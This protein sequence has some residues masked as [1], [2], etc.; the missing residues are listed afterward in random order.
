MPGKCKVAFV[1][2]VILTDGKAATFCWFID[3][4]LCAIYVDEVIYLI[5][6]WKSS[7]TCERL[8][9]EVGIT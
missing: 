2:N 8:G 9:V 6:R 1:L 3:V 5:R 4:V 7:N